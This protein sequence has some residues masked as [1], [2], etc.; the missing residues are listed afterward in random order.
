MGYSLLTE[1]YHYVVWID[2]NTKIDVARELYDRHADPDEN[3]NLTRRAEMAGVQ[4]SL[5]R[6]RVAGWRRAVPERN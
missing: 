5:E 1:S 6:Q 3:T 2:W 4:D